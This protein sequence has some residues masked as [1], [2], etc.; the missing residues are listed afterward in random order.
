MKTKL[1]QLADLGQA[2]WLDYIRRDLIESGRLE[3]LVDQGL[4][5]MTSNP[6]IFEKAIAGSSDYDDDLRR[7]AE[8]GRSVEE[9][10]EALAVDDIQRAVDLLRPVYDR[11]D[12][13]DG[14][15]S[16]EVDPNLAGDTEATIAEVRRLFATVD[17]PNVMIKVPATPAGFPAVET[18]IG[19]GIN[20]N[21][22]LIFSIKQYQAAA[23][24]YLAG[25]ERLA[26]TGG[27]LPGVASVASVFVSRVDTA[28]D[29]ALEGVASPEERSDLQGRIAIANAKM[30]YARF[31]EIFRGE[32]WERLVEQGARLQ[33]VLWGSTSTK[34]P[35]YSD[36]LYVDNLIGPDTVNTLPPATLEA[37][38]DHG[39]VALTVESELGQAQERLR[40][41]ADLG[42]DLD[43]ITDKLLQNGVI[44]FAESYEGL[45]ESIL[46]KRR[47]FMVE[48]SCRM[49]TNLGS[50][51]ETVDEA[52]LEIEEARI[53]QRIWAHDHTVWKPD[54]DEITNRLGWLHTIEPMLDEVPRLED[55][56][57]TLWEAGYRQALLLGMG[58]SSLAADMFQSAFGEIPGEVE[59]RPGLDLAVL[60]STD[61]GAVLAHQERLDPASTLFIVSTK[62]GTT[63]ET[64]S[65]FKYFYNWTV[66]AL[67]QD[68]AG[69]HFIAITDPGSPLV[70]LAERYRFRETFVNAPEIGGRYSALSYFGLVPAALVGVELPRLLDQA[71]WMAGLCTSGV[72]LADNPAAQLGA[73]LGDLARAGRDKATLVISPSV[74]TFG[75]WVEQLIAESTGKEGTGIVPIV[76]EPLAG[77]ALYDTDRLFFQ[78]ALEEDLGYSARISALEVTGQPVVRLPLRE[79]YD[80]GGEIF[81][82][83]MAVAIA[84]A[85]L[86]IHPFNQP[87]VEAAKRRAREVLTTYKEQGTLPQAEVASI[88]GDDLQRFLGQANQGDYIALL[89]YL[90]PVEGTDDLLRQLRVAL[91]DRYHLATTV[92]Y[93]PRYLHSTGQLHKGG[94][95]KGLF[96]L[97]TADP[98][99]DAPIPDQAGSP[100]SSISFG[101]L[102]RAQAL[103]DRQALLDAGRRVAH[104]HL[105]EDVGGGLQQL[106]AA[107]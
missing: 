106:L 41:L 30:L 76:G 49:E 23:E 56:L 34:D 91:R 103:G 89:A 21:V 10:Y 73:I 67:G 47:Q 7:L 97:L 33:R 95:N 82:W 38:I 79:R 77:P 65:L 86:G 15:V 19:E 2:I 6:S 18:L 29:W 100:D 88:E 37:F 98:D 90:Q 107:L 105:G 9:T 14:Y 43:A 48:R 55:L 50:H 53:V 39:T 54:P 8:E 32:R 85:R 26:E 24:A 69:E 60:D 51:Q 57:S 28:V 4:R 87:D 36:T 74:A 81:L 12:G 78:L 61:P 80:L 22:T 92:G 46:E 63:V 52:L 104:F 35:R 84:G 102:E 17:R 58:G 16:L 94:P 70:G 31:R 93:G 44:A 40:R 62:S 3:E 27:D 25:L 99:Q 5:G 101:T 75:D 66:E 45:L 20:I 72:S 42:I 96:I 13:L 68:R 1:D 83:E 11:T 59:E 71:Q 64:R